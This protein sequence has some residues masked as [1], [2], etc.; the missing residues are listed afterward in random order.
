MRGIA[1]EAGGYPLAGGDQP[2]ASKNDPVSQ[3]L[4]AWVLGA[5]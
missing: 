4:K 2:F 3:T 1:E 5:M